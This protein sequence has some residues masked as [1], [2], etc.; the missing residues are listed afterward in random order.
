MKSL[1]LTSALTLA[2]VSANAVPPANE[3][4]SSDFENRN[5]L[6]KWDLKR[7]VN[8]HSIRLTSEE[9]RSG[10]KALRFELRA[11][12][13][14]SDGFR[15]E[16]RD[17]Y[18]APIGKTTWYFFSFF[19]P[20][21]FPIT[22]SNSCVFAQWHDQKDPGDLDR[23]PPIAIRIRGTGEMHIT[24]RY[25]AKKI[26]NGAKNPEIKL[27]EDKK[28]QRGQWND[29]LMEVK[30][31][32]KK[33]GLVRIW[34]NSKMIV[35]YSGPIGYNDSFGP[36][37]KMGIYCRETPLYPLVGYHDNYRRAPTFEGLKLRV[38]K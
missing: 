1:L 33:D 30:W 4:L 20:E 10:K 11:N 29:I 28:F 8:Q 19:V 32:F 36:Y 25:H 21:I 34:R 37:L 14:V 17:P 2:S 7:L 9:V 15:S 24:G 3:I 26:Q 13:Y 22:P 23:N 31:S 18:F 38:K 12:D 16:I 5:S 35:N 6:K 27:Y